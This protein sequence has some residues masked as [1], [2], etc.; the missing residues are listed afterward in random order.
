VNSVLP[1]L[2]FFLG[3]ALG[4]AGVWLLLRGRSVREFERGRRESAAE[5]AALSERLVGRENTIEEL[6]SQIQEREASLRE[7]QKQ[8]TELSAKAAQLETA[9]REERRQA[10]EKLA[11]LEEA[12]TKLA[13]AFKA[14]AADALKSSNTAFLEL[15]KTHLEK[16]QEAAQG[17][18]EKRQLAIDGMV[19]P[20]KES[21]GKVDSTLQE[22]EKARIEA[23]AGLT[24][25]V[26]S[27]HETQD[28][29]K[30][31]TA[32]LV[33]SL[34]QPQARGRWGEIQL[35]R[36]VELAG[37]M[38]HC[39]F[40]EQETVTDEEN[41]LRP[42][43]I[44]HLPGQKQ[45]VVDAK[46]PLAAYLD[47]VEAPDEETRLRRLQ[48]HARQVREQIKK[49]SE[50]SYFEQFETSPDFVVLFIPGEVYFSAA[51]Q[52]DPELIA[53]GIER[54][55]I[56]SSPTTMIS[57]LRGVAFDIQQE[58]LAENA[59]KISTLGKELYERIVTWSKHLSSLGHNLDDTIRSY[60]NAVGSLES[61]V[62]PGARKFKE[63]GATGS[64]AE[65]EELAPVENVARAPRAPELLL[66]NEKSEEKDEE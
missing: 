34:R 57:I 50:K 32:N 23:Y 40:T 9:W 29:L 42:D 59:E 16:F 4:G 1:I 37:M 7:L 5:L 17:D 47:A 31:E 46:T 28:L 62:L 64:P 19:K 10:Q 55:V 14:L 43:M 39:D 12:K 30:S 53:F 65:I 33:K 24:T 58:K 36:V 15:A 48:D 41:R 20:V 13:D 54:K 22:I 56:L 2:L 61:R 66:R 35:R 63:L 21:L 38:E 44:I 52:I 27:L 11:L 51:L 6:K 25:Q 3:I 26:Q 18:L 49:L 8:I 60:N 45:L